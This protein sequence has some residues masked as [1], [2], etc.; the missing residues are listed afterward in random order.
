MGSATGSE[1]SQAASSHWVVPIKGLETIKLF[2]KAEMHFP[3]IP[4]IPGRSGTGID[5][6]KGKGKGKGMSNNTSDQK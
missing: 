4:P 1:Q 6:G 5:K 2:R 3:V